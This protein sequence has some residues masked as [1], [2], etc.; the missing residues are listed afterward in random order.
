MT[1]DMSFDVDFNK[2]FAFLPQARLKQG[3]RIPTTSKISPSAVPAVTALSAVSTTHVRRN[4]DT[5]LTHTHII[6]MK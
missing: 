4:K 5:R 1:I 6:Q 2:D 3:F